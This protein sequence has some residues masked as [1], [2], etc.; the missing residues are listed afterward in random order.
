[1]ASLDVPGATLD[2]DVVG[3]DGPPVVALHGLTSSRR[4]EATMGLDVASRV[5]GVRLLRYDARGHG[6]STGRREP[7]DY[8]WSALARD[9]AALLD[10]VFPGERVHGVGA[11]MGTGTLLHAAV[12]EPWRFAT[13]TLMIPPTAWATRAS[14]ATEYEWSARLVESSGVTAFVEAADAA[15]DPPAVA[16]RPHTVPDVTEELLPTVLRGAA[17]SDLPPRTAVSDVEVP[18]LVLA[19][20]DDPAHPLETA[21]ALVG[22]I[23]SSRLVVASRPDDVALWPEQIMTHIRVTT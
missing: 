23:P 6:R 5:E 2:F 1:M 4:R 8:R 17:A 11:S 10:H 3:T 16:G 21:D 9:L 7:G 13:L 18:T 14:K 15:P 19:W 12:A 20:T 22:L